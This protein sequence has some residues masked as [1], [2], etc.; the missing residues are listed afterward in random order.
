MLSSGKD[1]ASVL[2]SAGSVHEAEQDPVGSDADEIVEIA[3]HATGVIDRGQFGCVE[4]RN[5]RVDGMLNGDRCRASE[6]GK[7][8]H[9]NQAVKVT[10]KPL[11]KQRKGQASGAPRKG[12]VSRWCKLLL[13]SAGS[14]QSFGVVLAR[15]EMASRMPGATKLN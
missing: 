6:I 10:Q 13:V 4:F 12:C 9:R 11:P 15:L 8:A 2:Q 5:V 14:I 7:R 1:S 3:S